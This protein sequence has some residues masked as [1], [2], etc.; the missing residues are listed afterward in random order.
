[1]GNITDL[2]RTLVD[3]FADRL[4]LVVDQT[5]Y[6]GAIPPEVIDA[7]AVIVTAIATPNTPSAPTC[8]VQ[9]LGRFVD[10]DVALEYAQV[11][12]AIAPHYDGP[13]TVLKAGSAAVYRTRHAGRDVTGISANYTVRYRSTN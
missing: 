9:L 1:M 6:R 3:L 4:G 12:D 11:A 5:I 10:R 13:L 2:E 8:A 7:V